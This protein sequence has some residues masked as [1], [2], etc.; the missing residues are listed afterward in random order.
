MNSLSLPALALVTGGGT[1]I[2]AAVVETLACLGI[3][4]LAV[5]R[6]AA[7]LADVVARCTAVGARGSVVAV[8]ADVSTPEGRAAVV[9]AVERDATPLR[10]LVHNAAIF[11]PIKRLVDITPEELHE[12]MAIN[13]DGPIFLT[14]A[15]VPRL[16]AAGGARVLM[17]SSG[18][19]HSAIAHWGTY[20]IS[21]SALLMTGRL[22]NVELSGEGIAVGS[23]RPGVVD[24]PMQGQLREG[25]F[26][27][28]RRFV[29]LYEHRRHE[30]ADRAVA[31]LDAPS[32]GI[33]PPSNGLDTA[34][35][36]GR[37]IAW[38]LTETESKEFSASE[39]DVRDASHHSR[40]TRE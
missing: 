15:L 33:P 21:K 17:I 11:G 22:L 10:Y 14:S 1:G 8:Q 32:R 19:A 4:V 12:A 29:D 24:T 39:W 25:D 40:W 27:D 23:V 2:G 26:P 3:T 36:V 28:R 18:A 7:P 37:F 35:N 30:D 16:R 20:C 5:G 6:R 31:G 9:A 38:L 34:A 13:V